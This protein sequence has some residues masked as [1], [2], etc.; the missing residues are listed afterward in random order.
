MA[1]TKLD[2]ATAMQAL[3]VLDD[4]IEQQ[5][6]KVRALALRIH[7]G[8]GDED[9]RHV[10]DFPDVYEDPSFQFEEGQL[11]GLVAAGIAVKSQLIGATVAIG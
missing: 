3:K 6:K 7:P 2:V 11:A 4:M 8:L 1:S 9:L 5:R 10:R